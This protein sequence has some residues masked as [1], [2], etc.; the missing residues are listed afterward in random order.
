MGLAGWG[1]FDG[2][3]FM[4]YIAGS[5][6]NVDTNTMQTYIDDALANKEATIP[7][8]IVFTILVIG[9]VVVGIGLHRPGILPLLAWGC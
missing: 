4:T 2:Q 8:G 3:D 9:V 6:K 7:T 1:A 5:E